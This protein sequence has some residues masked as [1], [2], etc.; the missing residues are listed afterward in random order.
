[1]HVVARQVGKVFGGRQVLEEVSLDIR[2]GEFCAILGPS[3]S[4]KSTLLQIMGGVAV[5]DSGSVFVA[6]DSG[7]PPAAGRSSR[8]DIR[9]LI[10]WSSQ[11]S[12]SIPSRT[13][14]ENAALGAAA[15]GVRNRDAV[16]IGMWSLRL[17]G[18]GSMA[19]RRAGT[20]SGGEL[21]RLALARALA[22]DRPYIFADEPTANLDSANTGTVRETFGTLRAE[23]KGLLVATHDH[24][25]ADGADRVLQIV[26]GRLV[27]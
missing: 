21:Q 16:Q 22:S 2:P 7:S 5:P 27:E 8:A 6:A 9:R 1:M 24:E 10:C 15:C 26:D 12:H 18:L 13:V 17:L 23:G 25:L 3:G 20:L 11:A 14:V 19:T 4:G